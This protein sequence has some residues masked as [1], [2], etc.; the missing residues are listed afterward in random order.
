MSEVGSAA[1]REKHH[2][3]VGDRKVATGEHGVCASQHPIVTETMREI[4]AAGGNAADAAI[5]GCLVQATVS[6]EMTNHTGTVTLLFW[7]QKHGT[8]HDLNSSG[9][10]VPDLAPFRRVPAEFGRYSNPFAVAPGFMPGMKALFERFATRPWADL[11]QPAIHWAEEGHEIDSFEHLVAAQT[12]DFYL[13]TPSGRAH[14]T[15]NG[16]L[17]QVG[18]RWPK[19]E[20]AKTLKA[21]AT[22]GPDYFITGEWAR[23]FVKRAND[24]GWP[25]EMKHLT[26]V[27]PRW[28]EGRR[29]RHGEYEIVQLTPPERQ[30]IFSAVTLG[31][32]DALGIRSLGHYTESA[33]S[34]YYWAHALRRAHQDVG[35]INDPKIFEDPSAVLMSGDYHRTVARVLEASRPKIDLT[36]HVKLTAGQPALDAAGIPR[37]Y[38]GSSEISI[39]DARGN[40]LQLM[41]TLQS[42]GIPGEVVDGV[43]MIGSNAM[44]SLNASFS[45]WFTGG[46]RLR[47]VQGNTIVFKDGKPVLSLGTPGNT[48]CTIPQMLSSI[49]DFGMTPDVAEDAPRMHPLQDDY[50]LRIE[51][52]L[53][54]KV[55]AGITAMGIHVNPLPEYDYHMGSFQMSWRDASGTLRG[56]AGVRRSGSAA[57]F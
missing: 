45:G 15:P 48:Y 47:G 14:F 5:A 10:I 49:L 9:T 17:P 26:S 52:R 55:L 20:L 54:A 38:N 57:G 18:E 16:N 51:S 39:V 29:Y 19:P 24:L 7:D 32:L 53:P 22:E 33:E 12:V 41:N 40:W 6:H 34:L 44:T 27:P 28:G 11:C 2:A 21:L 31:V 13:Y 46:G 36:R 37:Q 42:G 30:A 35:F 56:Y 23:H 4:L 1:W 8:I 50:V 43:P 3:R 25:I